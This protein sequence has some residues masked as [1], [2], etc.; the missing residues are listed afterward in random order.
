MK[1]K[2][3]KIMVAVVAIGA[4]LASCGSTETT[5]DKE[6]VENTEEEAEEA[7]KE[8][9]EEPVLEAAAIEETVLLDESGIKITATGLEDGWLGTDL[10][11]LIENNGDTNVTVQVRNSSVNG[12]SGII[13]MIQP[14]KIRTDMNDLNLIPR[15]ISSS[16][17]Y[18]KLLKIGNIPP[19]ILACQSGTVFFN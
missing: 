10:K 13:L 17:G 8:V 18:N 4:L 12:P 11:L 14:G 9:A 3:V 2:I 6:I 1:R 16:F 19:I 15:K 5:I 7:T